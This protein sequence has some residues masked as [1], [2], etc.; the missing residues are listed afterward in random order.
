M[1]LKCANPVC[2]ETFRY[3]RQGR[4]FNLE[5]D[6]PAPGQNP[7]PHPRVERFWLCDKCAK[8]L[9]VVLEKGIVTTQPL[10][11]EPSGGGVPEEK[12]KAKAHPA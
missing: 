2:P 5:L 11:P 8:S 6:R 7:G 3:L 9:K 1:L 10:Y 4:I 12:P